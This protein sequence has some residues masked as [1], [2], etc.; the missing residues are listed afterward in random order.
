MAFKP[1]NNKPAGAG[2]FNPENY[3]QVV[4][5][6]GNQSAR[7]SLIVDLGIQNQE[8][9]KQPDGSFKDRKPCQQ[10]AV[11]VDLVDQ[12]V[13]YGGDIGET[14]YRLMVNQTW[15]GKIKGIN[16]TASRPT[17][18]EGN[19]VPGKIW[20]FHTNNLLSKIAK[21]AGVD[22][23]LGVNEEDNM[24]IEQLLNKPF[25]ADVEVRQTESQKVDDKGNPIVYTNVNFKAASK[26]PI[27][28]KQVI[29]VDE[30]RSPA[31]L[32]T[33]DNV[34]P[35]TAKL[36]RNN[37]KKM[38]QQATNYAGSKWE[39]ILGPVAASTMASAVANTPPASG[40]AATPVETQE[41]TSQEATEDSLDDMEDLP[42]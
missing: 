17:D 9:A 33:F 5:E 16:F 8:P 39:A 20:T 38:I 10:V 25:M 36:V 4:P 27:V 40:V 29:D 22:N 3:K 21:A 23:I 42:F 26:L 11:F 32:I 1:A 24:D 13:D 35:E 19:T 28:K 14:Q 34:T 2:S 12:I 15:S 18:A 31:L 6:A 30:L 7:V 37:I 41:G